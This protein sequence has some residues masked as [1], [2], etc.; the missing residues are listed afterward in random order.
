MDRPVPDGWESRARLYPVGG[1]PG[2]DA[3]ILQR[4]VQAIADA[5]DGL[6]SAGGSAPSYEAFVFSYDAETWRKG[7]ADQLYSC[8]LVGLAVLDCLGVESPQTDTPYQPRMGSAVSAVVQAGR[9]LGA[10]VDTTAID[11][12]LPSGPFI[13]LVGDNGK[14][15]PEHVLVGLD[16]LDDDGECYV[17]EGGQLSLHGKGYRISKGVYEFER[18]E[19]KSVWARRIAPKTNP[20]RE[21]RGY[22][23]LTACVFSQRATLPVR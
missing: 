5:V 7:A 17:F 2:G 22:I 11:A 18:R 21:L 19:S 10:W 3:V 12:E 14:G 8:A 23:D 13:A 15:G 4:A 9:D 1:V 16:G 6:D 20:W